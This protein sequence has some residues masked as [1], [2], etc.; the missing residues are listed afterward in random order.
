MAVRPHAALTSP[1]SLRSILSLVGWI[2]LIVA[3]VLLALFASQH[4][5]FPGDL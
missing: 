3:F 1:Q 4:A 2:A 5:R